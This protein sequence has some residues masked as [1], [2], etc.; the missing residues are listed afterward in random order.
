[1]SVL[2]SEQMQPGVYLYEH[3]NYGGRWIHVTSPVDDLRE[4]GFNDIVSSVRIV[5]NYRATFYEHAGYAG[6]RSTL[7]WQLG[8]AGGVGCEDVRVPFKATFGFYT[9]LWC[10]WEFSSPCEIAND[11][12]SSVYVTPSNRYDYSS[13]LVYPAGS[14]GIATTEMVSSYSFFP[15]G[16]YQYRLLTLDGVN[17]I[18]GKFRLGYH[19]MDPTHTP[20]SAWWSGPYMVLTENV[21]SKY[22]YGSLVAQTSEPDVLYRYRHVGDNRV[23]VLDLPGVWQSYGFTSQPSPVQAGAWL[24]VTG[25]LRNGRISSLAGSAPGGQR[26][27]DG[28][29]WRLPTEAVVEAIQQGTHFYVEGPGARRANVAVSHTHAGRAYVRTVGDGDPRNDLR[30][31]PRT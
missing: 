4:L 17:L 7:G 27:P 13:R 8:A 21:F 25:V 30:S 1:M 5:G 18:E 2:P 9:H 20:P 10:P 28:L 15:D 22:V 26:Y 31:L 16:T 12:I 6:A 3:I 11:Q 19:Y 29:R 24:R 14:W 23:E